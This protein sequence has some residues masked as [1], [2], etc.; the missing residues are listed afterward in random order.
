MNLLLI[1]IFA[2]LNALRGGA[3][4]DRMCCATGM[5]LVVLALKIY[6]GCP[7]QIATMIACMVFWG[8]LLGLV[9]GWGKYLNI[10]S[11]N[12]KYVGESEVKPIDWLATKICGTPT[13]EKQFVQWCFVAFTF[14]GALF[15]PIFIGLSVFNAG[16]PIYG[17][18]CVLM[19]C[20]YYV[21]RIAPKQHQVRVGEFLYGGLLGLLISLSV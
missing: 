1:P 13:N 6:Q 11:G 7:L 3:H 4:I 14:R 16:A 10:L 19:G 5:S 17:V 12:M 21:A 15:Y 18:G 2:I 20:V 9:F 8:M